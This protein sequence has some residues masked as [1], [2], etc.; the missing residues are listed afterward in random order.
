MVVIPNRL[1]RPIFV[2]SLVALL[3][4]LLV[5]LRRLLGSASMCLRIRFGIGGNI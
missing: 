1:L 3:D 5:R 4:V 2:V